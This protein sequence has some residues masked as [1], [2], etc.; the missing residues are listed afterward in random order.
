MAA[1]SRCGW[2]LAVIDG[3]CRGCLAIERRLQGTIWLERERQHVERMKAYRA[4]KYLTALPKPAPVLRTIVIEH[5][6]YDIVFDG[7]VR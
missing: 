2:R 1:C 3:C 7:A 5:V 4:A 6:E